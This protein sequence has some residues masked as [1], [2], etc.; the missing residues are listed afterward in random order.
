MGGRDLKVDDWSFPI[1]TVANNPVA[2][3]FPLKI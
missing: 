3:A 1:L 2:G